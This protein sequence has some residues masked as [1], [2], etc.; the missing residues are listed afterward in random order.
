MARP[1]PVV[2]ALAAFAALAALFT[3]LPAAAQA[4]CQLAGLQASRDIGRAEGNHKLPLH[5]PPRPAR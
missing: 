4:S 1:S 5:S 3:P 2:A